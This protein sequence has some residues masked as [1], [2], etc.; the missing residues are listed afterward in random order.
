MIA[1]SGY[2]AP[3]AARSERESAR[4]RA[5]RRVGER[6]ALDSMS[7]ANESKRPPV[8][9]WKRTAASARRRSRPGWRSVGRYHATTRSPRACAA[10]TRRPS[11]DGRTRSPARFE[12]EVST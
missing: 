3:A 4:S 12:F 6:T 10:S 1:P 7:S 11:P 9:V 8:A 5:F 2:D